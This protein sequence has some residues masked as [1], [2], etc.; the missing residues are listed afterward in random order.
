MHSALY[1]GRLRHRRLLPQP[2]EFSYGLYMS[3]LDLSELDEVFGGRWLWSH[4]RAAP[5]WLRRADY[6]GDPAV[7]LDQAVRDRVEAET[8][9]RPEGPIRLL[10]HLRAFGLA[11]NPVSFYYCFDASGEQLETIVAE[12]T[13]TPWNQR[14][15]YVLP[16]PEQGNVGGLRRH[17]FAKRFHVSPFMEMNLEYDWRFG[18][19]QESLGIHM[20]NLKDGRKV[21]DATLTLERQPINSA[22]LARVLF[23]FPFITLKVV[24]AIYWQAL[25]LWIKRAPFHPHPGHGARHTQ[26]GQDAKPPIAAIS[27]ISEGKTL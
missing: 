1:T 17:R 9:R 7:P 3:Y 16:R 4:R 5:M 11:F 15:A 27:P 23:M 20:S 13:N 21:F 10:T 12:I 8:G 6:L 26:E 14:H 19:P 24:A 2:H 18:L 22:N 25:R